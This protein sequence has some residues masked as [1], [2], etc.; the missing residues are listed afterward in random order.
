[1]SFRQKLT[2]RKS[3]SSTASSFGQSPSDLS[4]SD[5]GIAPCSPSESVISISTSA[6][7]RSE[8][9][10]DLL[11]SPYYVPKKVISLSPLRTKGSSVDLYGFH[12]SYVDEDEDNFIAELSILEPRPLVHFDSVMETLEQ[13]SP[14]TMSLFR[15]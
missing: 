5:S 9:H 12:Q 14:I 3:S 4:L 13:R 8:L 15:F 2:R 6:T 7:G 10:D 1:M 11:P